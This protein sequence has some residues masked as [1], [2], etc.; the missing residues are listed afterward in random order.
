VAT[1]LAES[2]GVLSIAVRVPRKDPPHWVAALGLAAALLLGTAP[3]L[4]WLDIDPAQAKRLGEALRAKA[5]AEG[6]EG[7]AA[8]WEEIGGRLAERRALTGL[9][10]VTWSRAARERIALRSETAADK[11]VHAEVARGW[12]AL[13]ATILGGGAAALLL[14]GYLAFHRLARYRIPMRILAGLV[15]GVALVLAAGLDWFCGA[16]E[17]AVRCG[18]GQ[19]ALLLGGAGLLGSV[20]ASLTLRSV[21]GVLTGIAVTLG[22]LTALVWAWVVHGPLT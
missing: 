5:Q 20:V 3:F 6:P 9:D 2:P 10:L 1:E 21:L 14:V 8:A 15:G 22:A 12:S 16:M 4:D 13:A 7:R 17:G 11:D 18:D 19:L